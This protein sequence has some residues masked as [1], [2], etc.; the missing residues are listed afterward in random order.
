[1][2][3][4][5][6]SLR[7]K[8]RNAKDDSILKLDAQRGSKA[9]LWRKAFQDHAAATRNAA[10]VVADGLLFAFDGRYLSL[11]ESLM[12]RRLAHS[13]AKDTEP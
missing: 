3:S 5:G 12:S 11:T 1:M 7:S 9:I 2:R 6:P 13:K 10:N 8:A 4:N